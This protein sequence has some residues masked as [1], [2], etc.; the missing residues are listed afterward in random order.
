MGVYW[1]GH[2][3]ELYRG[4]SKDID[5]TH[6]EDNA[7]SRNHGHLTQLSETAENERKKENNE[8]VELKC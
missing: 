6:D 8:L 5:N 4:A 7:S 3:N 2:T 1:K